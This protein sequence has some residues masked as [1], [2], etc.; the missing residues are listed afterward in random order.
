MRVPGLRPIGSSRGAAAC[1]AFVGAD[2][3]SMM[4]EEA[5]ASDAVIGARS[6]SPQVPESESQPAR[7]TT[8]STRDR[9]DGASGVDRRKR[10]LFVVCSYMACLC[11]ARPIE[12]SERSYY[13]LINEV[14]FVKRNSSKSQL[15]RKERRQGLAGSD[16]FHVEQA[17][18][19]VGPS[20]HTPKHPQQPKCSGP[21]AAGMTSRSSPWVPAAWI[22]CAALPQCEAW[23]LLPPRWSRRVRRIG[24]RSSSHASF[25]KSQGCVC[26]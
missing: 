16:L 24:R 19:Y 5:I 18:P 12:P 6:S 9:G 8:H 23:I 13:I 4:F 14:R 25:L 17:E 2:F 15:V 7:P 11:L 26:G 22:A 21:Q 10:Y 3:G 20:P 1:A